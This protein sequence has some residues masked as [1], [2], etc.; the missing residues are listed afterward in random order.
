M[1]N[2]KQIAKELQHTAM[3]RAF[4]GRTLATAKTLDGVTEE[5]VALLNRFLVGSDDSE[6]FFA[7]QG[8]VIKIDAMCPDAIKAERERISWGSPDA[9][10]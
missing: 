2:F 10:S 5:E 3:G 6:D 1:H 9:I 8:L 4:F 7:L